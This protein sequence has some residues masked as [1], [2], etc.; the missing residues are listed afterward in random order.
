MCLR[1]L[2]GC[3]ESHSSSPGRPMLHRRREAAFPVAWKV[4]ATWMPRGGI[5]HRLEGRCYMADATWIPI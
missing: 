4:E 3:H 5:Q 2:S 1:L